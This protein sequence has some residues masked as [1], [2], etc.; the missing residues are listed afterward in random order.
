[1]VKGP[2]PIGISIAGGCD[3][4]GIFISHLTEN[5]LAAK[6]GIEYGDQLLEVGRKL[7]C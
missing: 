2:E 4:G 3:S 5:S 6:A 1:M 7:A